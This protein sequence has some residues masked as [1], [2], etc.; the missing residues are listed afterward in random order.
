MP[1]QIFVNELSFEQSMDSVGEARRVVASFVDVIV[2]LRELGLRSPLRVSSNLYVSML[3]S[4]YPLARWLNDIGA[5]QVRR[6]YLRSQLTQA[7]FLKA[8][9]LSTGSGDGAIW[10]FSF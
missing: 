5:Y 2:K 4:E 6:S 9:D 1:A 3:A 7:G 10:D 8:S